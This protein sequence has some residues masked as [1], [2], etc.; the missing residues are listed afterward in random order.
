MILYMW[1]ELLEL[2]TAGFL[3][4]PE[5]VKVVFTDAG[6]GYVRLDANW[7]T[8]A[9]GVYYHTAMLDGVANQL[10]EMVPV[11]RIAQQ[12]IN[13]VTYSKETV[14]LIDNL[15]DLKPVPMTTTAVFDL[16]W[17]PSPWNATQD[18]N[19]TARAWY[20]RFAADYAGLDA[21]NA[22][23]YAEMWEGYFNI[24][25]VFS[26]TSDNLLARLG[27]EAAEAIAAD[28]VR[29]AGV[30]PATSKKVAGDAAQVSAPDSLATLLALN[31]TAMM[32]LQAVPPARRGFFVS[33]VL[34]QLSTHIAVVNALVQLEVAAGVLTNASA[35]GAG[36]PF[37]EAALQ[38]LDTLLTLRRVTEGDPAP[39]PGGAVNMPAAWPLRAYFLAD[40]LSDMNSV[41]GAVATLLLSLR[42][43][44]KTPLLPVRGSVWYQ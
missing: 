2:L 13:V 30:S 34:V 33:H 19:A 25:Y 42:S 23:I 6:S 14:M 32:L 12:L 39:G 9:A 41:R 43:P 22:A 1:Q 11:S 37:V 8:W 38:G 31:T 35:G 28:W 44:L 16:A 24:P 18:F 4:I 29:G 3:A 17:D 20:A 15:S 10:T 5:G 27:A 7:T 36:L 40:S 26:G 21:A